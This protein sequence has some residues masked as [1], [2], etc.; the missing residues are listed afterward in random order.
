MHICTH[1]SP[2]FSPGLKD[3]QSPRGGRKG[4]SAGAPGCWTA[5]RAHPRPQLR[6][7]FRFLWKR[8]KQPP[9]KDIPLSAPASGEGPS[10][11]GDPA[12]GR[13]CGPSKAGC[14]GSQCRAAAQGRPLQLPPCEGVPC[15]W[16]PFHAGHPR[17]TRKASYFYRLRCWQG[18]GPKG[19]GGSQVNL[20]SAFWPRQVPS[21]S[22]CL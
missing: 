10:R 9:N 2:S 4:F 21:P 12:I 16:E 19:P 13:Q 3:K 15:Q 6:P 20:V 22:G 1:I 14:P 5:A 17:T 11:N 8:A 7:S 18:T